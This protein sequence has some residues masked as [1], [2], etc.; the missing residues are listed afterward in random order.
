MRAYMRCHYALRIW[1]YSLLYVSYA[2]ALKPNKAT[3]MLLLA[4]L[5]MSAAAV[6]KRLRYSVPRVSALLVYDSTAHRIYNSP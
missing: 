4:E 2:Q 3:R 5:P 1:R 6:A